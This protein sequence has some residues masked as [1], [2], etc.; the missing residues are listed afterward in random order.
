MSKS[1]RSKEILGQDY[2]HVLLFILVEC[3]MLLIPLI[4]RME[5]N[6]LSGWIGT[7]QVPKAVFI[8]SK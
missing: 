8:L 6:A 7:Y 3:E 4:A 2:K 1:R 5:N